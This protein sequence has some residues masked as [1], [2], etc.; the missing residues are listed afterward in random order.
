MGFQDWNSDLY[1]CPVG[2]KVWLA[3]TVQGVGSCHCINAPSYCSFIKPCYTW[4][5]KIII[6]KHFSAEDR[7]RFRKSCDFSDEEIVSRRLHQASGLGV[8]FDFPFF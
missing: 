8:F 1:R 3:S 5:G 2:I 6:I 4:V 7:A